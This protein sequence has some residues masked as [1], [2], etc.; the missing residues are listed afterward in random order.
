MND[1]SWTRCLDLAPP[2]EGEPLAGFILDTLE[3]ALAKLMYSGPQ[4]RPPETCGDG[5]GGGANAAVSSGASVGDDAD[6]VLK[7]SGMVGDDNATM[8]HENAM[9]EL[10][11][12]REA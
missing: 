4:A 9:V 8:A 10:D 5:F 7:V 6:A 12:S 2:Y 11:L 1:F 3:A